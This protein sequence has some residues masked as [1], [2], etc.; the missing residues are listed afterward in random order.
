MRF[1]PQFL[2]EEYELPYENTFHKQFVRKN[3]W[4]ATYR[5]VF[6]HEGKFYQT[7]YDEGLT[8]YQDTELWPVKFLDCPEVQ[9]VEK[10]VKVWEPVNAKEV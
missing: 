1:D 6:Q 3:R 10:V 8:E 5:I 2:I 4:Y 7:E 9:L